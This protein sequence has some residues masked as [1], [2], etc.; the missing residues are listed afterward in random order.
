MEKTLTEYIIEEQRRAPRGTDGFTALLND[1]RLACKRLSYLIGKGALSD[2]L[3]PDGTQNVRGE[4]RM[5]LDARA[6]EIFLRTNEWG[7]HLA[8]MASEELSAPYAIPSCYPRGGYLLVFDPLEGATN[9]DVNVTVGSIFSVYRCP[10]DADGTLEAH[11][12]QPGA[13][14]VCAGYALYGPTTMLVISLGRGVHGFTLDREIGEFIH[15]HPDLRVAEDTHEFAIN[16]SNARFWEPAVKRYVDECLAGQGGPRG[17][18]FSMR[19]VASLVAETHRILLRG[20]VFMYP[21]DSRAPA[22]PGRMHLLFQA[23]P[24]AFLIEQAGG[25]ASSGDAPIL[26]LVPQNLHQR[27]GLIFGSRREVEVLED[28][29]RRHNDREYEAP[30]FG[31]RGLFRGSP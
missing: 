11:F 19:W 27:I 22:S 15:T 13:Q 20:G 28:Y 5:K 3:G 21:R 2:T 12:L 24:I 29:H 9:V 18:D 6:N 16:A 23:N 14:Q 10:P 1:I 8:G 4:P 30:L 31:M 17:K 25:R 26:T 7:G